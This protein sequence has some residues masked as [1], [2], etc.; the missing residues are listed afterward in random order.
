MDAMG[1]EKQVYS[2]IPESF[3]RKPSS[4]IEIYS[5]VE[6]KGCIPN[7]RRWTTFINLKRGLVK[8]LPMF[9]SMMIVILCIT[10]IYQSRR[11]Q[12]EKTNNDHLELLPICTFA[13][14]D[15]LIEFYRTPINKIT[16]PIFLILALYSSLKMIRMRSESRGRMSKRFVYNPF[17]KTNRF[18]S[19]CI[20]GILA[21]EVLHS[22]EKLIITT[23]NDHGPLLNLFRQA[24]IVVLIGIRYL[25]ILMSL[26]L[27]PHNFICYG[28]SAL[29]MWT[30][31]F[32][33]TAMDAYCPKSRQIF[34]IK[35]NNLSATFTNVSQKR[36]TMCQSCLPLSKDALKLKMLRQMPY[37]FYSCILAIRLTVLFF[38][39]LIDFK[40]KTNKQSFVSWLLK[41]DDL[42][43]EY[44][45]VNQLMNKGQKISFKFSKQI[46]HLYFISFTLIYQFSFWVL[47]NSQKVID[48]IYSILQFVTVNSLIQIFPGIKVFDLEEKVR[49]KMV[50][51]LRVINVICALVCSVQLIAGMR[52]YRRCLLNAYKGKFVDIPERRKFKN[53]SVLTRALH[54]PGFMI[55]YVIWG[56]V[57]I[58]SMMFILYVFFR[59]LMN[60]VNVFE[61]IV[62]SM[63]PM[64]VLLVLKLVLIK[65]L[66]NTLFTSNYGNSP[67]IHNTQLLFI[68]NFF[69]LFF[70]CFVGMVVCFSRIAQTALASI[71]FLPRID[72][73][74]FGR[75]LEV[76]DKGYSSY[77]CWIHL[78]SMQTNPSVLVFCDLVKLSIADQRSERQALVSRLKFQRGGNCG[79][80]INREMAKYFMR[81]RVMF[82]FYLFTMLAKNP[83]LSRYRKQRHFGNLSIYKGDYSFVDVPHSE[84]STMT[85]V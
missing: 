24:G 64:T 30:E 74:I 85:N 11:I 77:V 62:R 21:L 71:I 82:R 15:S 67:E 1:S 9:M 23:T 33:Q 47:Q 59:N 16:L 83:W 10:F 79:L 38:A 50:R 46:L 32:F 70:D 84:V 26:E 53:R 19:V 34:L 78:E 55:G 14:I 51:D 13:R 7:A 73:S 35:S 17:T 39:T 76:Y 27:R 80:V 2:V 28:L 6:E 18:D 66:T 61:L 4:R 81:R 65:I 48:E 3:G 22:F 56:Y 37:Y 5:R 54:F 41:D 63:L 29:F 57:L 43:S 25:P 20:Y 49:Q 31:I 72:Q 12:L 60:V 69:N 8:T 75:G 45:H 52:K 68:F 40:R 44:R 58:L 36:E 42:Q